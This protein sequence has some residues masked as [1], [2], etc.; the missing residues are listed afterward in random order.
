MRNKL[1][2]L[3]T[4]LT[5]VGVGRIL[6]IGDLS[7]VNNT[8]TVSVKIECETRRS[9]GGENIVSPHV[10]WIR[11]WDTGANVFKDKAKPGDSVSLVGE[12]RNQRGMFD[13]KV[14]KFEI[15]GADE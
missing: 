6:E 13:L 12:I 4:A 5:F 11:I 1:M 10:F 8:K 2:G 7:E 3:A 9:S 15:Y 14:N